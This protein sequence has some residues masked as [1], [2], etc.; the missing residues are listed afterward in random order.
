MENKLEK[1]LD[2]YWNEYI[3]LEK[4]ST[5]NSLLSN[6]KMRRPSPFVIAL[7]S[8]ENKILLSDSLRVANEDINSFGNLYS[9]LI[10]FYSNFEDCS[11]FSKRRFAKLQ[12]ETTSLEE[13]HFGRKVVPTELFAMIMHPKMKGFKHTLIALF[14]HEEHPHCL[15]Q[16]DLFEIFNLF[17]LL[18]NSSLKFWNTLILE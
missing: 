16:D 13:L 9:S 17:L 8:T 15:K 12:N 10:L 4:L 7:F 6:L 5:Y 14:P 1:A 2:Y 18:E 3:D 11:I